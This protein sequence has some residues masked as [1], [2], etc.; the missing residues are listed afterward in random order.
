MLLLSRAGQCV[1]WSCCQALPYMSQDVAD[2]GT[3]ALS[4]QALATPQK[5]W[6]LEMSRM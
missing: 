3:K 6:A 4:A 1:I 5:V 2:C